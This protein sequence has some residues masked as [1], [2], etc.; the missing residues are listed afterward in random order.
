[1]K[2]VK[3]TGLSSSET[4]QVEKCTPSDQS[5]CTS[6]WPD[7]IKKPS[8]AEAANTGNFHIW[9]IQFRNATFAAYLNPYEL[10]SRHISKLLSHHFELVG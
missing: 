1:M 7:H 10:R 5:Q 9:P 3:T 2:T 6:S 8:A 4:Y